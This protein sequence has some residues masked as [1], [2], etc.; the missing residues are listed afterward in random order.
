MLEK[1]DFLGRGNGSAGVREGS[2]GFG[3][4]YDHST[5]YTHIEMA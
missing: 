2:R 1:G 3:G 5:L 4:K